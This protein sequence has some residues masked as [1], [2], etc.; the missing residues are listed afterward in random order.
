MRRI[1]YLKNKN[2]L[3]IYKFTG[4]PHQILIFDAVV[5]ISLECFCFLCNDF[6]YLQYKNNIIH[7]TMLAVNKELRNNELLLERMQLYSLIEEGLDQIK[8]D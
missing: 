2:I 7:T 4:Q 3:N 1:E 5:L 8:Q 6:L